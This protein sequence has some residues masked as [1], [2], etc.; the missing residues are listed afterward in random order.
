[1]FLSL[2]INLNKVLNFMKRIKFTVILDLKL[3][4]EYAIIIPS[5]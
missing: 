1:M 5:F 4:K 3:L 2:G